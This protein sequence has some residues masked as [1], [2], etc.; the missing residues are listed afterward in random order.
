MLCVHYSRV[1]LRLEFLSVLIN[2]HS[3][4]LVIYEQQKVCPFFYERRYYRAGF[5]TELEF[6]TVIFSDFVRLCKFTELCV[7]GKYNIYTRLDNLLKSVKKLRKF[8]FFVNVAIT[9]AEIL[10]TVLT[11]LCADMLN[12][13]IFSPVDCVN[14]KSTARLILDDLLEFLAEHRPRCGSR[15]SLNLHI[16]GASFG[17]DKQRIR[18]H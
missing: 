2:G 6:P 4:G 13:K 8:L 14:H 10:N 5:L 3:H 18:K 9:V 16:I 12:T 17:V 7:C 15:K 11:R 1:T